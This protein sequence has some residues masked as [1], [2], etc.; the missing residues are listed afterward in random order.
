[1]TFPG[2]SRKKI[3]SRIFHDRGN[4]VQYD[5]CKQW[6]AKSAQIENSSGVL[7]NYFHFSEFV[8]L[9]SDELNSLFETYSLC[10]KSLTTPKPKFSSFGGKINNVCDTERLFCSLIFVL[11]L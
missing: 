11:V 6:V 5:L 10:A 4:P 8:H 2:F 1:M 9:K 7:A 3:F